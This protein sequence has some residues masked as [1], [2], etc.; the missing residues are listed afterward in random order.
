M[1]TRFRLKTKSSKLKG[2]P[3][4]YLLS[5]NSM[6]PSCTLNSKFQNVAH[7]L[8]TV[9]DRT[10][11]CVFHFIS[12]IIKYRLY[13]F[14]T[15]INTYLYVFDMRAH[16][17]A[18]LYIYCTSTYCTRSRISITYI[19]VNLLRRILIRKLYNLQ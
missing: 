10:H 18:I 16:K 14:L 4:N 17:L 1:G 3:N 12:H 5:Q 13:T 19:N 7:D 6:C 8:H 2:L 9:P 15:K 11:Y